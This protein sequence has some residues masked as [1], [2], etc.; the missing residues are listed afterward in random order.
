M[1]VWVRES[2]PKESSTQ[3][4]KIRHMSPIVVISCG[5]KGF[6][7]LAVQSIDNDLLWRKLISRLNGDSRISSVF[8]GGLECVKLVFC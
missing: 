3:E 1:D 2:A 6:A 5:P 4:K 8:R 7:N